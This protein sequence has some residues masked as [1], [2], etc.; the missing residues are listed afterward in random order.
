MTTSSTR[1]RISTS[2]S[3]KALCFSSLFWVTTEEMTAAR[4]SRYP[5][6]AAFA[7]GEL[8]SDCTIESK[9]IYMFATKFLE[10]ASGSQPEATQTHIAKQ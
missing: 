10:G 6:V 4:S 7:C 5:T 1:M 8:K 9:A 3:F 2:L